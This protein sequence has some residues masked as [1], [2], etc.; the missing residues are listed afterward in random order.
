MFNKKLIVLILFLFLVY[1][2]L[3]GLKTKNEKNMSM[4][5]ET[6]ASWQRILDERKYLGAILLVVAFIILIIEILS[7]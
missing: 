3:I 2:I 1:Y 5:K 7:K 6:E 4:S